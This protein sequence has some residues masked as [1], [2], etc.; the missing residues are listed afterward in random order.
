MKPSECPPWI[1]PGNAVRIV[2]KCALYVANLEYGL[3]PVS[4]Q[5]HDWWV[6]RCKVYSLDKFCDD[7]TS[8]KVVYLGI[9]VVTKKGYKPTES[10]ADPVESTTQGVS[11][12]LSVDIDVPSIAE[13]GVISAK[14]TGQSIA[15]CG[16]S[17]NHAP[18]AEESAILVDWGKLTIILDSLDG[19]AHVLLDEDELF[20]AMGFKAIDERAAT[21][22]EAALPVIPT[23]IQQDMIDAAIVV[24]D[25]VPADPELVWDRDDPPMEVGT[26][27]PSMNE[28][29]MAVKQHAI[30][31]EFELETKKSDKDRFRG[32]CS[33]IG[34]PWKIRAKTQADKTIRVS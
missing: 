6:D 20:D 30:V 29:R 5:E 12:V 25:E 28:F 24:S 19:D 7:M 10:Y 9:E 22:E 17:C 27:Y 15:R 16:D 3:L 18:N 13:G 34:C 21:E 4:E 32:R 31:H 2:V 11:S 23:E 1:D 14:L 26:K 33:A 8:K